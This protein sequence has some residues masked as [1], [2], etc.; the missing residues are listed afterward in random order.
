[1]TGP[2]KYGIYPLMRNSFQILESILSNFIIIQNERDQY[3]GEFLHPNGKRN[4]IRI[5]QINQL[6]SSTWLYYE[7]CKN[8]E[9]SDNL[10]G[11]SSLEA[12]YSEFRV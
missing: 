10:Q 5:L 3:I 1:M 9:K 12:C 8:V 6:R 7:I 11:L 2:A 4:F